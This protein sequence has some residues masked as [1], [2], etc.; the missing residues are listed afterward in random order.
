MGLE[1]DVIRTRL[2]GLPV[3]DGTTISI[4]TDVADV[5]KYTATTTNGYWSKKYDGCIGP[6]RWRTTI[7][8]ETRHRSGRSVGLVGALSLGELPIILSGVGNGVVP[9]WKNQLAVVPGTGL[10][11]LVRNGASLGRGVIYS[12]WTDNLNLGPFTAVSGLAGQSRID[13][14]V[15]RCWPIDQSEEGRS[16]LAIVA[17]VTSLTPVAPALSVTDTLYEVPLANVRIENAASSIDVSKITDRRVD[18]YLF[19]QPTPVVRPVKY[20]SRVKSGQGTQLITNNTSGEDIPELQGTITLDAGVTYDCLGVT[21]VNTD[22]GGSA[23]EVQIE[24]YIAAAAGSWVGAN[25]ETAG[26]IRSQVVN[27]VVSPGVLGT[28]A[29]VS[30]GVRARRRQMS[31]TP[32]VVQSNYLVV[33]IPRTA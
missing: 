2:G 12:Q 30:C 7:G 3:A 19:V 24:P 9:N 10:N 5:E 28:G 21:W 6:T 4:R 14:V 13:T 29:T 23:Q 20:M 15:V 11:V 1:T 31:S 16:E 27:T 26:L 17:G 25:P 32:T 33:A 18:K 8:V 22:P